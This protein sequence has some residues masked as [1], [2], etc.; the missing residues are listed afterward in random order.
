MANRYAALRVPFVSP[1][2]LDLGFSLSP[3]VEH[4]APG[5]IYVDLNGLARLHPDEHRLAEDLVVR[6]GEVGLAVSVAIA[7][8]R[9][10]ARVAASTKPLTV[11]PAGGEAAFLASF[12][13]EVLVP[14]EA[15][16]AVLARWGIRTLGE[17]AALPDAGLIERLGIEGRRLQ[18]QAQGEDLGPFMPYQPPAVVDETVELDWAIDTVEAVAFVLSSMLDRLVTRLIW[19]GW[20]LGAMRL[21]LGLVSQTFKDYVLSLAS[22]LSDGRAV[23][24]LVLQQVRASPPDAA[25]ER[26]TV[27]VDPAS[28]RVSQSGLFSASRVSPEQ[29]AATLVRLEALVGPESVGSPVV[30]DSHR[31]DAFTVQRF[32][33]VS[34]TDRAETAAV[35]VLST[36][37]PVLRRC[38]PPVAVE[39]STRADGTPGQVLGGPWAGPV[40]AV[41]GPWRLS[42]DW[43][44]EAGWRR[45]EWDAELTNGR[46]VRLVSDLTRG[47]WF[48]EGVYD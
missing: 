34:K 6:A 38:R 45:D 43:W 28:L 48:I 32:G 42:G 7:S 29:L 26:I 12:P 9:T 4:A 35:G 20:A 18:R 10:V 2:L 8:T 25:V 46:V 1:A 22:P 41:A 36:A 5:L 44:T 16:A 47:A 39:V 17:L 33:A 19:R 3:R 14:P 30:L 40:R 27:R 21:R 11:V 13:V 23:L 15:L 37:V 31:P 24:P